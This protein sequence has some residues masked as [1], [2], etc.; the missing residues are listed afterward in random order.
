MVE[1]LNTSPVVPWRE[2]EEQVNTSWLLRGSER[3]ELCIDP[4]LSP[5]ILQCCY[6]LTVLCYVEET[7]CL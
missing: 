2:L 6:C 1:E 3:D 5:S 4:D 7:G